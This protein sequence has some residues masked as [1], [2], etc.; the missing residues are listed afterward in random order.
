MKHK[1]LVVLCSVA[2]ACVVGVS[3]TSVAAEQCIETEP[4]EA[5]EAVGIENMSE[6]QTSQTVFEV[7]T[8][9][10]EIKKD[11]KVVGNLDEARDT[12]SENSVYVISSDDDGNVVTVVVEGDAF[13]NGEG[14]AAAQHVTYTVTE[15]AR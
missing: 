6:G 14:D 15:T 5:C 11:G 7:D 8:E 4:L 10:G 2:A 13:Q 3:A 12:V 1:K 9:T